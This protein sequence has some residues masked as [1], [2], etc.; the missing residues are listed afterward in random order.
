MRV[1]RSPSKYHDGKCTGPCRK[2]AK[3]SENS[4]NMRAWQY[5]EFGRTL[6]DVLFLNNS[7][8][9]PRASLAPDEILV[10]V[11][12]A[13]L[14][15]IDFELAQ[16]TASKLLVKTPKVPGSDYCGRVV[17]SGTAIDSIV[18]GQ[19]VFGRVEPSAQFG[20]LGEYILTN[21]SG[22]LPLPDEVEI[23]HAAAI[24]TPGLCAYQAIHPNV[25]KG[26]RVFINGGSGDIGVSTPVG[27]KC[28]FTS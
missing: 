26:D 15:P 28:D 17:A 8:E 12:S 7:A 3:M 25:Q 1:D 14:N 22:C 9:R 13:A 27:E 6:E 4:S 20:T 16:I 11:I 24:G 21:L 5:N 19:L 18:N 23:D 10:K 2:Q